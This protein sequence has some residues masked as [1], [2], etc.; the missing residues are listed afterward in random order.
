[1]TCPHCKKNEVVVK[2]FLGKFFF[3]M[4]IPCNAT[5]ATRYSKEDAL[6]AVTRGEVRIPPRRK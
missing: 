1:M 4:C 2:N 6:D 3:A 5:W